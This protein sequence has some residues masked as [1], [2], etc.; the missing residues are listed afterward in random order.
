MHKIFLII[1]F[2]GVVS[3]ATAQ[4]KKL[5]NNF[6]L[7]IGLPLANFNPATKTEN[8]LIQG[9]DP[10]KSGMGFTGGVFA[11]FMRA[12]K[13]TNGEYGPGGGVKIRLLY[14]YF[15]VDNLEILNGE[16]FKLS[17]IAG[18]VVYKVCLSSKE[19]DVPPS[20]DPD[21]IEIKKRDPRTYDITYNE[22]R[23][24]SGYRTT[25]SFFIYFGPQF[26]SLQSILY[27]SDN[28]SYTDGFTSKEKNVKKTDI[29]L[30]G[31][32]ELWIGRLYLDLSYQKGLQP[33]YN[34]ANVYLNGF[35]GKFGLAF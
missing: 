6:G 16:T 32:V 11:E 7:E 17:Y 25:R 14:N 30:V 21:N 18:S 13:K 15:E 5:K 9:S 20:K 3:T 35:V 12:R 28:S 31:G 2:T 4:S 29:A 24:Y 19:V 23:S 27:K 1:L 33:I 8:P 10:V 26:S 22:G 34:G